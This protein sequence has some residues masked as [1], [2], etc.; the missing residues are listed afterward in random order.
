[1]NFTLRITDVNDESPRCSQLAYSAQVMENSQ[2]LIPITI[3][4]AAQLYVFDKDQVNAY[5][6]VAKLQ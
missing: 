2:A 1:M 3:T 6:D 5:V 4:D